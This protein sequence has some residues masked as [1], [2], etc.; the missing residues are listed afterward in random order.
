MFAE[1]KSRFDSA[2][3]AATAASDPTTVNF[4]TL[5][6]ARTQ[7]DLGNAAAAGTD[8]ATIAS[9]FVVNMSTDG[10]NFRR[11]N[12]SFFTINNSNFATV[13]PSFR[14]LTD[15]RRARSARRGDEHWERTE[16][17]PARRS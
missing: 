6:R 9:S 2:I 5:G 11:Q 10:I 16:P 1:A 7:L 14:G 8:A 3:V 17:R 12:F 15:Q 13:D 4:A